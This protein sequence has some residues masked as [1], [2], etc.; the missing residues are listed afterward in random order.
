MKLRFG[1][2]DL[3]FCFQEQTNLSKE[4]ICVRNFM[5]HPEGEDEIDRGL[6]SKIVRFTSM[7]TDSL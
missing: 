4:Y 5:H 3:S 7:N 1:N 2:K 6:K